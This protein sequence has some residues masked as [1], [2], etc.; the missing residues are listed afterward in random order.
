MLRLSFSS[1]LKLLPVAFALFFLFFSALAILG[2]ILPYLSMVM[3]A[4]QMMC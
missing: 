4:E 3:V 2:V 1:V